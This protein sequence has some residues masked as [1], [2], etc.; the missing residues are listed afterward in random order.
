MS[1][2]EDSGCLP[3]LYVAVRTTGS[4]LWSTVASSSLRPLVPPPV[5][6]PCAA[7]IASKAA[8][9]TSTP[10][11]STTSV[12]A[13]WTVW[14]VLL[15]IRVGELLATW[16]RQRKWEDQGNQGEHRQ[17]MWIAGVA[18]PGVRGWRCIQ[19]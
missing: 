6:L 13:T 17:M 11:M 16:E 3:D 12:L 15:T 4:E 9:E 19:V 14:P 10:P 1:S 18:W 8:L 5:A 7:T 2:W